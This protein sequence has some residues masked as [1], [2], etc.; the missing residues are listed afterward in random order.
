MHYKNLKLA[1]QAFSIVIY[2]LR[3]TPG[4]RPRFRGFP[5]CFVKKFSFND[6]SVWPGDCSPISFQVLSSRTILASRLSCFLVSSLPGSRDVTARY[7][8]VASADDSLELAPG[9]SKWTERFRRSEIH[10]NFEIF[11]F[12]GEKTIRY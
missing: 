3:L 4:F 9:T 11:E 10:G 12:L 8:S 5:P 2:Y 1:I 6:W 7:E